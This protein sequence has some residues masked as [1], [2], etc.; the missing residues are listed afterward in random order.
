MIYQWYWFD[1]LVPGIIKL[2]QEKKRPAK[3]VMDG[4]AYHMVRAPTFVDVKKLTKEQTLRVLL[5]F[6]TTKEELDLIPR[7]KG[8][9]MSVRGL[10]ALAVKKMP[11]QRN[12]VE[13]IFDQAIRKHPELDELRAGS[14]VM[15]EPH[16]HFELQCIERA[17]GIIKTAVARSPTYNLSLA[18][19]QLHKEFD[20]RLTPAVCARIFA[21][22]RRTVKEYLLFDLKRY[23]PGGY[24]P[25][26]MCA[27]PSCAAVRQESEARGAG[28]AARELEIRSCSACGWAYH[29][30]CLVDGQAPCRHALMWPAGKTHCRCGCEALGSDEESSDASASGGDEGAADPGEDRHDVSL[31]E[32]IKRMMQTSRPP[33]AGASHGPGDASNAR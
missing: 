4:A 8:G 14:K 19:A 13:L 21:K 15:H 27:A 29:Q 33:L 20:A 23:G 32:R 1:V 10:R 12:R 7:T 26:K 24:E 5:M 2:M 3:P 25:D 9:K 11:Y 16:Y 17:W 22:V 28:D 6:G 18:M 31:T 30:H